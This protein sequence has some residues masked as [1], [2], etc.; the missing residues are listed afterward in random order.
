MPKAALRK[1]RYIPTI[2]YTMRHLNKVAP[3]C[4]ITTAKTLCNLMHYFS[5]DPTDGIDIGRHVPWM[6]SRHLPSSILPISGCLLV[7][8]THRNCMFDPDEVPHYSCFS[9]PTRGRSHLAV[10][11]HKM[12]TCYNNSSDNTSL[13]HGSGTWNNCRTRIPKFQ[14]Q[15]LATQRRMGF[16][17][18][19]GVGYTKLINSV[20]SGR[21]SAHRLEIK[22]LKDM[23]ADHESAYEFRL[24]RYPAVRRKACQGQVL[25]FTTGTFTLPGV[26]NV[27]DMVARL[28][29][30]VVPYETWAHGLNDKARAALKSRPDVQNYK[31]S[32][33]RPR[34]RALSREQI[35]TIKRKREAARKHRRLAKALVRHFKTG[36]H[37]LAKQDRVE[38]FQNG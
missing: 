18:N 32:D 28:Y 6:G 21:Y 34:I 11:T 29:D 27:I 33:S 30:I 23:L 17:P 20:P 12:D 16:Q 35:T 1:H 13:Q 8:R 2:D 24:N 15:T 10:Q 5:R 25:L 3:D 7:L 37:A 9:F 14:A 36:L 31:R 22:H 4:R 26:K 38:G 19:S